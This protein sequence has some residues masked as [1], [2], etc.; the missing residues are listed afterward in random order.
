[1]AS[2]TGR[3]TGLLWGLA[4]ASAGACGGS[5][6]HSDEPPRNDVSGSD[7]G[8]DGGTVEVPP[9]LI[10]PTPTVQGGRA[11]L[12]GRPG[13]SEAPSCDVEGGSPALYGN[14]TYDQDI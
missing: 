13:V 8:S 1:M 9:S 7:G 12:G 6:S 2:G 10:D 5:V 14:C 3:A 11:G 4:F